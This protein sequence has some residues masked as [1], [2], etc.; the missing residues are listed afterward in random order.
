MWGDRKDKLLSRFR[1]LR[2]EW[3]VEFALEEGDGKTEITI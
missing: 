2:K 3:R 1:F